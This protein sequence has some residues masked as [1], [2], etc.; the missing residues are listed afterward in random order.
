ML[1]I[2]G[3][4]IPTRTL[5]L[6]L[7]D[8]SLIVVGL[9]VGT[10]L[11]FH[12]VSLIEYYLGRPTAPYRF[13]WVVVACVGSLY[14]F[15]LYEFRVLTRRRDMAVG[16]LQSLGVACLILGVLYYIDPDHSLGRGIAVLSA[17]VIL[18]LLLSWRLLIG[19]SSMGLRHAEA[20]LILGTGPSGISLV[21][22]ILQRPELDIKVLGFLDE[23]GEN[24]GKSLINPGIVGGVNDVERIAREE[25]ADRVIL[26]LKERRG[27]TPIKQL[28]HLKF[29]GIAV[30]DAHTLNERITGKILLEHL[31][32]SWLILSGGFRQSTLVLAAKRVIDVLV[33][34]LGLLLTW[35]IFL[36][37]AL[38]I[39]LESGGPIF[40]VQ[41]RVGLKEH[42]F[43]LVKFRSMRQ[44]AEANG[45]Q[46][47]S[48]NDDRVTRVGR[49]IRKAR[50]DEM[51]QLWNLFRGE[52]S[53]VGPRP[54]RP[55]FCQ[56][57]EERIPLYALRHSVRPGITGWAQ[58]K[59]QYG[60]S[61][62][63]AK[64]KL[65][66]DFFYIK[67]LSLLLDL[68]IAFETAKVVLKGRGAQ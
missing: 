6:L 65:E 25:R 46:W 42:P 19:A 4:R 27:Q 53:L 11:R 9:L 17:P 55:F 58:V 5:L 23:K 22:E 1:K 34:T 21:R 29:A 24:I 47:A 39:F 63:D 18:L 2:G 45:P 10:A 15:D 43:G 8:G 41:E 64:T 49:F 14:Y 51:P 32:P 26:A 62:E 60:S 50:L 36:L 67:H 59:Y 48:S 37:V 12:N 54:E 31:S 38:A 33:A 68:A 52:M 61:I 20:I 56:L 3:Q 40:F 35:P 13:I 44:D 57:L 66:Y 16:M 7:C 30:E 28:L